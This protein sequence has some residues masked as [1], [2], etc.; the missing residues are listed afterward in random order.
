[1]VTFSREKGSV[2]GRKGVRS[3]FTGAEQAT[4]E[5]Y[6]RIPSV[7]RI[8]FTDEIA[9]MT[10]DRFLG[11]I[12]GEFGVDGVVVGE[13]FRFG[14][15]RQGTAD[16]LVRAGAERGWAVDIVSIRETAS[17]VPICST[18][19]RNALSSGDLRYARELLGYPYFCASRV[20]HGNERGRKL[21][22][23]TANI[24]QPPEKINL[25]YG[26]YATV[27]R[28]DGAWHIGAANIGDNPT[29][30]DVGATSFEVNL[31]DYSGDL[32]G[33]EIAVFLIERI[34]GEIHFDTPEALTEQIKTDTASI[35]GI[36]GADLRENAAFWNG[37]AEALK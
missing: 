21:G 14:R 18:T 17:G 19:V 33:N 24:E 32:Y 4:L 16:F 9:S 37:F 15:D 28:A 34:R 6:F 23:P 30:G 7:R 29:F 2:L 31:A 35:V 25:P 20:I 11:C 26:V 22:F 8:D 36:C 27:V 5:R 12:A 3:L 13:D 1:V 10:P